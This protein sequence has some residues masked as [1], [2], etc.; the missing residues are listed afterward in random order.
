MIHQIKALGQYF[1]AAKSGEKP[2]TIRKDDRI[3]QYAVGDVLEKREID[4]EGAYTG[5]IERYR[6]TYKLTGIDGLADGYCI[7]GITRLKT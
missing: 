2:F 5:N 6:V 1:Q 4:G 3:P 7:L